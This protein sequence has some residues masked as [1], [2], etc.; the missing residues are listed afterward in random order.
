MNIF[1]LNVSFF[2]EVII[3]EIP[4]NSIQYNSSK[5]PPPHFS[6]AEGKRQNMDSGLC[7]RKT[8]SAN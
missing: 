1:Q 2:Y 3:L 4:P 5:T 8:I 6:G 7:C